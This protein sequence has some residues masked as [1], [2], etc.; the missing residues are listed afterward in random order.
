MQEHPKWV[1]LLNHFATISEKQPPVI[2]TN[3]WV[4]AAHKSANYI[5]PGLHNK[6]SPCN[7]TEI[8]CRVEGNCEVGGGACGELGDVVESGRLK[9]GGETCG[10]SGRAVG[11]GGQELVG[12][13]ARGGLDAR[14]GQGQG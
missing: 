4:F 13:S 1:S 7:T 9:I 8:G 12:G 6:V 3:P 5:N 10:G 2:A 11:L 14:A